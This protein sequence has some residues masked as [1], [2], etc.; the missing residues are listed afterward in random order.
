MQVSQITNRAFGLG[1]G[2]A[3]RR[4]PARPVFTRF[5]D[6]KRPNADVTGKLTPEQLKEV[7]KTDV[8]QNLSPRMAEMRAD[9]GTQW[10]EQKGSASDG[11]T[12]VQAF[13]GPA[14]ETI[15]NRLAMLGVVMGLGYEAYTGMNLRQQCADHPAIVLA[16]FI[17]F[18]FASY[19]PI[20]KGYTRK[21]PFAWGPWT[22]KAENWNG[23]IAQL[24][25]LGM[26]I[27]EA[28]THVNTLQAWGLQGITH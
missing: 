7:E 1:K 13:D 17:I 21:E 26:V 27:T 6:D 2:V 22:P 16:T 24:G 28:W 10:K 9:L 23:R 14:P 20:V 25:F 12:E 19:V 8:G 3:A 5:Q 4:M 18:A 11:W 15:N